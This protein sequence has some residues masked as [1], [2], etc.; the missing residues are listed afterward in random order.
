MREG[1]PAARRSPRGIRNWFANT[2]ENKKQA[3]LTMEPSLKTKELAATYRGPIKLEVLKSCK[4]TARQRNF[5]LF[6]EI[7]MR[8]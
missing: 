5:C 3:I 7:L 8:A 1:D 6:T 4:A 2:W